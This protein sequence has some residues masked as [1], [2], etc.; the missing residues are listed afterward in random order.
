MKIKPV[1]KWYDLWVGLY[2][3]RRH[4]RLFVLPL[5]CLGVMFDFRKYEW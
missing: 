3:D 2:W 4:K 1:F 5:P